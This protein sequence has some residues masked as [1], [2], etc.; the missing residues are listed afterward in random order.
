MPESGEGWH[1]R[2][3]VAPCGSARAAFVRGLREF[4]I[5]PGTILLSAVMGFGALA[6]DLG[7]DL[8]VA[9][10]STAAIF[11]LPGQVT[12]F[13]EQAHGATLFAT[14]LAVLLTAT[15]LLPMAVVLAPYLRGSR[16]PKP[17]LVVAI[18]FC[19]VTLWVTGMRRLPEIAPEDRLPY[20]LGSAVPLF[21]LSLVTTALGFLIAGEVPALIAAS[22]F[23]LTPIYFILS[24]IQSAQRSP[25]DKLA[26]VLGVLLGPIFATLTPGFD[27]LL[28]GVVGGAGAYAL[29]RRRSPS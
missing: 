26:I 4:P 25:A 28:A 15:R 22:L 18:H 1:D 20:F 13:T 11:A 2:V 5:V 17:L 29:A 14:A 6:R 23:F 21:S 8:G 10:F 3:E 9:V 24:M 19:A 27:L 16:L 12:L 7:L